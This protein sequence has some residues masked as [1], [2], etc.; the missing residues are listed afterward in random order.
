MKQKIEKNKSDFDINRDSIRKSKTKLYKLYPAF[1]VLLVMIGVSIFIW[2][3][4]EKSVA[5]DNLASFDKAKSSI[6]QRFE[7][8][9]QSHKDVLV[10]MRG[11][12]DYLVQVVRDYFTLYGT[13]P[14]KT[15]NSILTIMSVPK[16]EKASIPEYIHYVRSQGYYDY[17]IHP[18]MDRDVYY[19][20]EFVVPDTV[21]MQM[22]GFDFASNPKFLEEIEKARDEGHMIVTPVMNIRGSD[23]LAIYMLSPIYRKGKLKESVESRKQNFEG[24]VVL[25]ANL[26]L[27]LKTALGKGVATDTS[28]VFECFY[29]DYSGRQ[30]KVFESSNAALLKTN[31]HPT[32]VSEERMKLGDEDLIIKFSAIPNFGG[33]FKKY[34]PILSLIIALALSIIIFALFMSVL[35]GRARAIEMAERITRSQRRIVESS[36]DIVSVLDLAGNWISMNPASRNILGY[37]PGDMIGNSVYSYLDEPQGKNEFQ[38]LIDS[39]EEDITHRFTVKMNCANSSKKWISWDVNLIRSEGQIYCIGRD[40]TMEKETEEKEKIKIKEIQLSKQLTSELSESK[41]Y[42]LT[43]LNHQLRNSLTSIIGFQQ[44]LI[45]KEYDTEEEHDEFIKIINESSEELYVN[46]SDLLDAA[47]NK[48]NGKTSDIKEITAIPY[49]ELKKAM[50]I[51]AQEKA[52]KYSKI[53]I[54]INSTNQNPALLGDPD[55]LMN[56]FSMILKSLAGVGQDTIFSISITENH[57]ESITEISIHT[58]QNQLVSEM[59][60]I[61]R[62]HRDNLI[63]ALASDKHDIILNLATCAS[64]IRMMNGTMHLNALGKDDGNLVQIN[65]PLYR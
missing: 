63:A 17:S 35:T 7:G 4:V 45:N 20:S 31:Y 1:I 27:M 40:I 37:N 11:L 14:T 33:E 22:K 30:R 56:A 38:S 34:L 19:P 16:V 5:S 29:N 62:K 9:F 15:Y 43:K 23:T 36:Y 55:Y 47:L 54:E 58:S 24:L 10:S 42:F 51:M 41:T 28:V 59:I 64:M 57:L 18:E 61:Y 26:P 6:I 46:V 13:V 49:D 2:K 12:Y 21:N 8:N 48:Q 25:E 65:M 60:E 32:L 53:D 44:M 39:N 52:F 3:T 50:E